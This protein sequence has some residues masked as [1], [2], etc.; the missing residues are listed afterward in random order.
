MNTIVGYGLSSAGLYSLEELDLSNCSLRDGAF[1]DDFGCLVSLKYLDLSDN[2]FS[3]L[4]ARFNQLSKLRD[5]VLSRCRYLT[6]LGT[7]LPDSLESVRVDLC[8]KL[9]TFLDPL[10]QCNLRCC[11]IFCGNCFKLVN[12]QGSKRTAITSLG[13]YLQ[14]SLYMLLLVYVYI[15]VNIMYA[16][17]ISSCLSLFMFLCFC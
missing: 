13:R 16:W 11:T 8:T 3:C 4:P 6:S 15:M 12:R 9:H 10:S 7:E 1:P 17:K 2:Y 14:V 5:L